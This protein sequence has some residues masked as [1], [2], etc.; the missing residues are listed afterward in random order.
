MSNAICKNHKLL[1]SQRICCFDNESITI[2]HKFNEKNI[3]SVTFNFHYNDG[4][5]KKA[6]YEVNSVENGKI[7]FD[8]YNFRSSLGTG[9]KKPQ[10]IAK[11]NTKNIFIVFFV[12]LLPEANPILD[13]SLYMEE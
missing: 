7:V 6:S 9:L 2:E 1:D 10:R 13:Y 4:E 5:D 8:L 3:L 12:T 11:Y